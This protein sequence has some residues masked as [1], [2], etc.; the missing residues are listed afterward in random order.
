MRKFF[1][2][3]SVTPIDPN[4]V[5]SLLFFVLAFL[6]EFPLKGI[7]WGKTNALIFPRLV[8]TTVM[9]ILLTVLRVVSRQ[10]LL[11]GPGRDKVDPNTRICPNFGVQR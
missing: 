3:V 7:E 8:C 1:V 9:D 11:E 10:I 2:G 5:T 4:N 6:G